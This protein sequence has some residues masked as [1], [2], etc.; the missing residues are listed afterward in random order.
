MFRLSRWLCQGNVLVLAQHVAI[1]CLQLPL[2]QPSPTDSAGIKRPV[3]SLSFLDVYGSVDINM[4]GLKQLSSQQSC[5][6]GYIR[7]YSD[8]LKLSSIGPSQYLQGRPSKRVSSSCGTPQR[9]F[10]YNLYRPSFI[11]VMLP[12]QKQLSC[13][14]NHNRT[15]CIRHLCMKAT[16]SSF[17][18]CLMNTS[19]E[20]MNNI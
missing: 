16:V 5:H 7:T 17:H 12:P 18:R 10:Q 11:L 9:Q 4:H 3:C 6:V 13:F 15:A 2:A 14:L 1:L 8:T 20:K 19:V